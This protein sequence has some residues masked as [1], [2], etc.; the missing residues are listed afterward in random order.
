MP[1]LPIAEWSGTRVVLWGKLAEAAARLAKGAYVE[2]EGELRHRSY[3]K[4][5]QAGKKAVAI[6]MP[7][8]EVHARVLRKLDRCN[9]SAQSEVLEE[10]PE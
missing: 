2:I 10:A 9:S 3:Q 6:D 1:A 5:I 4:E 7:V 8:S